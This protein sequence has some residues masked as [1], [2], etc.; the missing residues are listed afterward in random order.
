MRRSGG[1]SID[2]SLAASGTGIDYSVEDTILSV[3][4]LTI[5]LK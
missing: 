1:W 3:E 4:T 2:G 5:K